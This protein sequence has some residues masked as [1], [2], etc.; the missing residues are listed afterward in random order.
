MHKAFRTLIIITILSCL[1]PLSVKAEDI[2]DIN[3]LIEYAKEFDGQEVTVQGEAIGERMDRGEYSWVNIND[4]SNAMG[5]WINRS[6]AQ[7]IAYYGNYENKGD[8][9][10]IT[11]IFHR[12]CKEHGGE[13]DIHSKSYEVVEMGYAIREPISS[14]KIT[15]AIALSIVALTMLLVVA[16]V[17]RKMKMK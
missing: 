11:G 4:G 9:V 8:T 5:I 6:E 12:A 13:A 10:K 2:I 3:S 7:N 16:K 14:L 1:F 17:F 15:S